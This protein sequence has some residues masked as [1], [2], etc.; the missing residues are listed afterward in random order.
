MAMTNS[1]SFASVA[2][3]VREVL[4]AFT[5]MIGMMKMPRCLKVVVEVDPNTMPVTSPDARVMD[6]A[7]SVT[8]PSSSAA[9]ITRLEPL[10]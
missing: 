7:L 3:L 5:A 6:I 1:E 2:V 10:R 9:A 8:V 4:A